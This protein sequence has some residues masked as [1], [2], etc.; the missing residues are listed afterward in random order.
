MISESGFKPTG[1]GIPVR[2]R[3]NADNATISI[4]PPRSDSRTAFNVGFAIGPVFEMNSRY[5][6]GNVSGRITYAYMICP[7]KPPTASCSQT[8]A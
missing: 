7:K 4:G 1:P 8:E 3:T 2:L 5:D 6:S